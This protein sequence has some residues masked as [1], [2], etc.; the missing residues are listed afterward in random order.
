MLKETSHQEGT[1]EVET[2]GRAE[3]ANVEGC[4]EAGR[5][6]SGARVR[7]NPMAQSPC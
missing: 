2:P 4:C 6:I 3:A 7:N 1:S 5:V